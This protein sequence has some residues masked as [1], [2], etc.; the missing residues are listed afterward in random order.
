MNQ[1]DTATL[2]EYIKHAIDLESAVITQNQIIEGYEADSLKKKPILNKLKL[3]EKPVK[4][5][6]PSFDDL[7][8]DSQKG[9]IV[10]T[11]IGIVWLFTGFMLGQ[12]NKGKGGYIIVIGAGIA[13]FVFF[14]PL[15]IYLCFRQK[16][17]VKARTEYESQ[18]RWY[19]G[20]YKNAKKQNKKIEA[21][22]ETDIKQWDTSYRAAH[23]L[24]Y[25]KLHESER[26]L[27][28]YYSKDIIF[29]KYRNLPALTMI[30][31]Y[32]STG[33]CSELT[34]PN[35]AYNLYESELRQN[36]II[37]QL[38]IVISQLESIRYNQYVLY[39]EV[40]KINYNTQIIASEIT[41]IRGYTYVLTGLTALN[42]YYSG[43]AA[44][45]A[46]AM[47][48]YQALS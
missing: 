13:A 24:L 48:F 11:I 18:Y 26:T 36:T 37:S 10:L 42:T 44:Q 17:K 5:N 19:Q 39:E 14:L 2:T 38:N 32:L 21:T 29:P 15:I 23:D 9:I 46:S 8:E 40:R 41:A 28:R 6:V 27:Q 7:D 1:L 20:A 47:A 3:P 4:K 12:A 35:G 22:Y 25:S 31:E 30:Y 16:E 33:R 43:I 45:S 34:G